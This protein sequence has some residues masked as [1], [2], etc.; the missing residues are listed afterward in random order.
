[1]FSEWLQL[2]DV[3]DELAFIS[4]TE[5]RSWLRLKQDIESQAARLQSLSGHR[6]GVL[7]APSL[8]SI[9]Q[10]LSL[11]AVGAHVFLIEFDTAANNVDQWGTDFGWAVVFEANGSQRHLSSHSA[12]TSKTNAVT[13]L[14]S[15]TTGKPKAVQH[16]WESLTRPVRKTSQGQRWLLTYRPNLYAGLQVL[17]QCLVN[18]GA[19]VVPAFGTSAEDVATLAH[20]AQVEFASATPSYWRWLLTLAD[21]DTLK[22]IPL[23]QIT[24]GGEA[25]DQPTLDALKNVFRK[26]RLVHIYATTELGRCFSVTDGK[27]GFPTKF[28]EATS[29]DG[30]QMKIE[31]AELVVRSANA[32]SRYDR[33]DAVCPQDDWFHTGDLVT[34][35]GDRVHFV[36]RKSDM[37]NVGGNK[38]YPMEVENV[39]RSVAGVADVRIYGEASSIM[40][41]LVKC[42]LVVAGGFDPASVEK[43]VRE[44]TLE[45]L[46]SYQRPRFISIVDEI[47]RTATGKTKRD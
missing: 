8:D 46:N 17:L 18:H 34:Y 42:D 44:K 43:A 45:L 20:D 22:R 21:T 7:L 24:L 40:G 13:I 35:D 16:T 31:D 6:V 33:S 30:I 23:K 19:L 15:G 27:A 1:M 37:I 26:T 29:D 28:L 9:T 47:P 39:V 41:Q 2:E 3:P 10:L 12:T 36:G 5:Q 4:P 14:T 25:V 38:V 32:M 11:A